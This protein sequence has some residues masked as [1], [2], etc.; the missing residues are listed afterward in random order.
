VKSIEINYDIQKSNSR[1]SN[2]SR[3]TAINHNRPSEQSI[4]KHCSQ[5]RNKQSIKLTSTLLLSTVR[6]VARNS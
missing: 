1:Y 3:S 4:N 5:S 6:I 2:Q